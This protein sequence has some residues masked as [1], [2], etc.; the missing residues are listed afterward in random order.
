MMGRPRVS[1]VVSSSRRSE[2]PDD[3][4]NGIAFDE[5]TGRVVVTGKRWPLM[6]DISTD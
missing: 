2:D 4:L 5:Q 1:N 6:F 3:V